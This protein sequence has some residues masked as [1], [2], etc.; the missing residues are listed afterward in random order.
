DLFLAVPG[1]VMVVLG[2]LVCPS[3][4]RVLTDDI[5]ARLRVSAALLRGTDAEARAHAT[6][7]LREGTTGM[8]KSLR[9]AGLER[10]WRPADLA[11]LH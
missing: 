7:L 10:L 1:T 5:A 4:R 2:L 8:M 3:P 11:C 6:G 9:M